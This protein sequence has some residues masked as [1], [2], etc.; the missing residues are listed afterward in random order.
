MSYTNIRAGI[1]SLLQTIPEI[2]EVYNYEAKELAK[3]PSAT[4]TNLSHKNLFADTARNR[5]QYSFMIRLYFRTDQPQDAETVLS[6]IAD[7]VITK[8]ESDI[9]LNSTCDFAEPLEGKWLYQEREIPVRVVE[10]AVTAVKQ[11]FR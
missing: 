7:A 5:R 6:S 9:T 10:I 1:V 4:V 3:Y 2:Q 11:V 8:I